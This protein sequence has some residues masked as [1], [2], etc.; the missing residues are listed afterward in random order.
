MGGIM[1]ITVLVLGSVALIGGAL[2]FAAFM[3]QPVSTGSSAE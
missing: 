3:D 1:R 2:F